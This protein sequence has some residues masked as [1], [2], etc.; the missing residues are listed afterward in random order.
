MEYKD[1][2][3]EDFLKDTL[4]IEWVKNPDHSPEL[5]FF[6]DN[7]LENNPEK[8]D[9]IL[10]AKDI[11]LGISYNSYTP[12]KKETSEVLEKILK[13]IE[14]KKLENRNSSNWYSNITVR[15][16]ASIIF[17]VAAVYLFKNQE[18]YFQQ[19]QTTQ[20]EEIK[21]L[22]KYSP[23]GVKTL[24]KL[25]DGSTVKLNSESKLRIPEKFPAHERVV[26][27]EGE[28]FFDIARDTTSPFTIYVGESIF[29]KV[30]GTS[31][32]I[33]AY[34]E[35]KEIKVALVT[36]KLEVHNIVEHTIE[37]P[38]LLSPNQMFTLKKATG[39]SITTA[40][41]PIEVTAWKDGI[42]YFKNASFEEIIDKLERWYDVKFIIK[43]KPDKVKDFSG[44]YTGKTL[45]D[46]LE[47]ISFSSGFSFTIDHKSN[48]VTIN[49]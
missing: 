39:K 11:L 17:I 49:K 29:T 16:A 19:E 38:V 20:T 32:N 26:Y 35:K 27:L 25:P 1:Y 46:V 13:G 14:H 5:D 34:P 44:K 18:K 6:W 22:S 30:L 48:T 28:A 31:F 43:H 24:F 2:E 7:W 9:T 12:T 33:N 45:A 37:K 8:E 4:F 10:K 47:G 42:I 21:Y 23:K 40:F 41:D 3:I 15:I 36:G